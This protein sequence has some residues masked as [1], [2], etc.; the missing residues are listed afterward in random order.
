MD[1][2][3]SDDEDELGEATDEQSYD[4]TPHHVI[5]TQPKLDSYTVLPHV[6]TYLIQQN[7]PQTT[8]RQCSTSLKLRDILQYYE[9]MRLGQRSDPEESKT[10]EESDDNEL[11]THDAMEDT[12]TSDDSAL[13]LCLAPSVQ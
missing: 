13:P 7:N 11:A 10:E 4:A 12:T 3:D 6:T 1:L 8:R 5:V 9:T 2:S